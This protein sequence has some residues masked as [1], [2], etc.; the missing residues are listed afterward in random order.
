MFGPSCPFRALGAI[1]F[2]SLWDFPHVFAS[3]GAF[4]G[5]RPVQ[6]V[7]TVKTGGYGMRKRNG[8]GIQPVIQQPT[9]TAVV[10]C[11]LPKELIHIDPFVF[12]TLDW[13]FKGEHA[14]SSSN[15]TGATD[16]FIPNGSNRRSSAAAGAPWVPESPKE[17]VPR[18]K[19]VDSLTV[20]S[21]KIS[22][23]V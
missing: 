4:L 6:S 22:V 23:F 12:G 3:R 1:V 10:Y 5:S 16:A 15:D 8:C 19:P 9:T 20:H 14:S 21:S 17:F 18:R 2:C 11:W 13:L 7:N